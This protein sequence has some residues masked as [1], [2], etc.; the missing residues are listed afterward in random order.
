MHLNVIV[1]F[2]MYTIY[3][4]NNIYSLYSFIHELKCKLFEGTGLNFNM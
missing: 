2:E 4:I 3:T 1:V